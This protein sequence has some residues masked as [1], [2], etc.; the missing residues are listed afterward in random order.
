ML[1]LARGKKPRLEDKQREIISIRLNPEVI[2]ATDAIAGM[3]QVSRTEV[4]QLALTRLFEHF[5]G[6]M[7]EEGKLNG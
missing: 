7:N 1:K 5:I 2:L 4:M 6:I 3:C